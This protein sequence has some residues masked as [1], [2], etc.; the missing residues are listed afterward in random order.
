MAVLN[1]KII[2][3]S[4]KNLIIL[5]GLYGGADSWIRVANDLSDYFTIHLL[6]LRNHGN[7]F[8][9]DIH[10]YSAMADDVK[11]YM[12]A[13]E[14]DSAYFI[15]HSMGGK[16]LMNFAVLHSRMVMK[17][18]VADISP[19]SNMALQDFDSTSN[20]HL[21][22]LSLMKS[23]DLSKFN[24]YRAISKELVNR[25]EQV[26]NVILKNIAK[27]DSG[28]VWKINVEALLNNLP[29]IMEGLDPDNFIDTKIHTETL[30][31]KAE[32][33]NYITKTDIKLI[34]FIFDSYRIVNIPNA[35]H[36]VHYD[37]PLDTSG[38]IIKFLIEN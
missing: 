16:I 36:W 33:S 25:N 37:N 12:D 7:S 28:F 32:N 8:R 38:E 9:S 18:V 22:L 31:L 19:R 35:G 21:N 23:L 34:D 6:D 2:G 17:M 20:F 5:H 3:S 14:I 29:E 27:T 15:G 1:S 24:D 13:K 4:H 10:T 26:R 30:F 11:V